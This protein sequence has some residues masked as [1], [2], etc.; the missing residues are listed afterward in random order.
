MEGRFYGRNNS[1]STSVFISRTQRAK[2]EFMTR[3][4][5]T[6]TEN[7]RRF[8]FIPMSS[9]PLLKATNQT[10]SQLQPPRRSKV[11]TYCRCC[12]H[13]SESQLTPSVIKTLTNSAGGRWQPLAAAGSSFPHH[14]R[15]VE[16]I[17]CSVQHQ[18]TPACSVWDVFFPRVGG[19]HILKSVC[20][21]E[22]WHFEAL[23]S[24][25]HTTCKC[26]F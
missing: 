4:R 6:S 20:Y 26:V 16:P 18:N 19:K 11:S 10:R 7:L 22:N 3:L 1:R 25:T 15:Q 24:S 14:Q 9:T 17:R 5:K 13:P 12:L 2:T 8:I 23:Q 21:D